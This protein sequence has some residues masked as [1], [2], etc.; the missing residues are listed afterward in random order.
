MTL[1]DSPHRKQPT[2]FELVINLNT[3][4]EGAKGGLQ[5]GSEKTHRRRRIVVSLLGP[6]A[7]GQE[8]QGT[9]SVSK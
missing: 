5:L 1:P 4:K 6:V 2:K 7:I 3:A 8:R 9:H